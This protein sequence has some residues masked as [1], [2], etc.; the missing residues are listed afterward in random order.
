MSKR[1]FD[2]ALS[3]AGLLVVWPL[4]LVIALFIKLDSRGPVFFRQQR[5]GRHGRPFAILKFRTMVENASSIGPRLTQKRDPR[6]T[7]I[8]QLLRWLKLDELPQLLNVLVGDMS[9]VGPRPEDP[10]FVALYTPEQRQVLSVRP[11]IVGPSQITG[12]DELEKYPDDV[13]DT[14]QYYVEHILPEKL[15]TDLDYVR[16]CSLSGDLRLIAAGVLATVLGA[17]KAKFFR[18][19]REAIQLLVLDTLASLFVYYMAYELKF[20]WRIDAD[21]LPYLGVV[22]ALILLI[23]PPLFVYFGLYQNILY[24]LGTKEFMAIV[25]AVTTG[26]V[27]ITAMTFMLG[28]RDHSRLMFIMDWGLLILMLFGVRVALKARAEARLTSSKTPAKTVLIAGADDTGSQL[29]TALSNGEAQY[30]PVGFLDDD[31]AKRGAI[32]HGIQVLGAVS[33]LPVVAALHPVDMVVVLFPRVTSASLRQV[34]DYCRTHGLEYR[35]VPTLDRLLRGDLVLPELRELGLDGIDGHAAENGAAEPLNGA[36]EPRNGAAAPVNGGTATNGRTAPS[37]RRAA[38]DHVVLVTGGAGYVGSHV[39]RKLLERGRRVRVLDTY[40][41]GDH[42]LRHVLGHPNLELIEGDVRNLR[43]MTLA[44]RGTH[45]V[46]ALAALVGDPA[47][48]VDP[49]ETMSINLEATRLLMEVCQ[50]TKVQRLVFASSCSVYGANSELVLNEGSW[51]NPVSLY[52]RTRIESEQMLL[53]RR[54]SLSTVILRLAT[55]FGW[56][57]RMR[58]DLLVNTFTAHAFF[59]GKIRI[60][61]GDQWRPNLHAQDAAE[62]F[63]QAS[64]ADDATVRGEIFNVGSNAENYTVRQIAEIVHK[65][66]PKAALEIVESAADKR[67]YRVSFDK[68]RYVMGFTPRH[69]VEDGVRELLRAFKAGELTEPDGDRYSNYK[70]LRNHGFAGERR[71]LASGA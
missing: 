34:L 27:A 26:S 70:F 1:L 23:R 45:A 22:T 17:F 63:I 43:T 48:E 47:C 2:L 25:K 69:T 24:Y 57:T 32:I 13:V 41:Y 16:S 9:L 33:D 53:R 6:I 67:D 21:A 15:A 36:A 71:L 49:D 64:E 31:P 10:H 29:V 66:V 60:F 37:T 68:I 54:D 19:R 46:I 4:L 52:A 65:H 38:E 62:A 59:N 5:I 35:L 11:G 30:R 51:L 7:R 55:V 14:E 40:L 12:R 8:G 56:S 50:T 28:F 18:L 61:G 3:A 20:D 42:G 58:L 39:V 44:A